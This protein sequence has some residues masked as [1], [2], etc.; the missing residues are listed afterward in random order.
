[1][2]IQVIGFI[3]LIIAIQHAWSLE[4]YF[5]YSTSSWE[6]C[7]ATKIECPP[8]DDQ[9]IKLHVEV[10]EHE[11]FLKSCSPSFACESAKNPICKEGVGSDMSCDISCCNDKDNCNNGSAFR[12]S[13][14]LLLACALA[15]LLTLVSCSCAGRCI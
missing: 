6:G 15:S 2:K 1:M 14:L 5:C 8:T 7:N 11:M 4:C 9:C 12:V 13:G 10:G 3:F